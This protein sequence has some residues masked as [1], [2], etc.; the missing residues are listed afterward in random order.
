M[1]R[2]Y[3]ENL[4]SCWR[5]HVRWEASRDCPVS[6]PS[7]QSCTKSSMRCVIWFYSLLLPRLIGRPAARR[8]FYWPSTPYV[9]LGY[10][11]LPT[12]TKGTDPKTLFHA[13]TNPYIRASGRQGYWWCARYHFYQVWY[14]CRGCAVC[15]ART[16][17]EAWACHTGIQ[18]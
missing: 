6:G 2:S 14:T 15:R 18:R 3:V 17:S 5:T 7:G 13:W 4:R 1:E 9:S 11:R 10:Q 16:W 12:G 8:E